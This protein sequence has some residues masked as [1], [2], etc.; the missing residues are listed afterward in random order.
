[1]YSKRL[2]NCL[3]YN[4]RSASSTATDSALA[5]LIDSKYSA[6]GS[7]SATMPPP[8]PTFGGV[9]KDD[10][11]NSTQWWPPRIVPPRDAPD[12]LLILT[13]DAGFA[14]HGA[15]DG[16]VDTGLDETDVLDV[17]GASGRH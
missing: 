4:P 2:A 15:F 5:L 6:V 14:A 12:I 10:A 13:D 7:L 1:M 9:I 8:A 11:L 16:H 3:L 17:G